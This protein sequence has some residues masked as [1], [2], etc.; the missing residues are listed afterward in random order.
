LHIGGGWLSRR[1]PVENFA[2][3]IDKINGNLDAD[4]ILVGGKEGGKSEKGLNEELRELARTKFLD[5]TNKLTLKQLCALFLKTKVFIANDSGPMHI[6]SAALNI[7]TI[8]LLGPTNPKKTRPYGS[9]AIT[10]RHSF[11]CQPENFPC[12][13]RNCPNP[14]CMKSISVEEVFAAVLTQLKRG[15][16]K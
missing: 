3:L 2:K 1:W 5:L 12:V 4:I 9:N 15:G 10:I 13:N 8:G 14:K 7:A 16:D 6:A 11:A